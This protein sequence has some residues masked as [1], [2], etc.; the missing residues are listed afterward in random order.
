MNPVAETTLEY[1]TLYR[2]RYIP[3]EKVCLKSDIILHYDDQILL[4]EWKTIRPRSD[5][6]RGVSCCFFESGIKISKFFKDD[7]LIYHYIDIV[8]THISRELNEIVL[9][10][11]LIDVIVE[12]DGYVKVLDLDQVP[13]AVEQGLITTKQAMSAMKITAW[14]LDIIYK[15]RFSELLEV[16]D[17][18]QKFNEVQ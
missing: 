2:R 6:N 4:T 10:D 11:L 3:D 7:M 17:I 1:P 18:P 5:F 15:G 9:N 14:L 12:N 8:E 16:F 13:R